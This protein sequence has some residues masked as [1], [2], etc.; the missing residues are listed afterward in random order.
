MNLMIDF[1]TFALTQDAAVSSLGFAVF[2]HD[3]VHSRGGWVIN[4]ASSLLAGGVVN[5]ETVNWWKTQ[6]KA[7]KDALISGGVPIQRVMTELC[8]IWQKNACKLV[9][10]H[11][12]TFDIPIAE[13]YMGGQPPWRYSQHRDTRTLFDIAKMK[14][15]V[16]P[17]RVTAHVAS[18]DALDQAEDAIAALAHLRSL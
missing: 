5:P 10:S 12:A 4:V 3:R 11:G 7:A 16:K 17:K 8:G 13:F 9:W 1:E 18:Q 14:G 6:E 2:D 15:W